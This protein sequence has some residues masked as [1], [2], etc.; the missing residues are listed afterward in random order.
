MTV[1]KDSISAAQIN[2]ESIIPMRGDKERFIQNGCIS[3]IEKP[4]D[5]E[6]MMEETRGIIG[7]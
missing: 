6:T 5:P 4:I 1:G 3:H 2:A 7:E